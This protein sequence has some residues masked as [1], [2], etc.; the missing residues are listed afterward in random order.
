MAGNGEASGFVN[1]AVSPYFW[2]SCFHGN[3]DVNR[4]HPMLNFTEEVHMKPCIVFTLK[5]HQKL[6]ANA[7]IQKFL[8]TMVVYE[9]FLLIP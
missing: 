2:T 5:E 6:L 1:S 9:K 4:S 8:I 7:T 3:N